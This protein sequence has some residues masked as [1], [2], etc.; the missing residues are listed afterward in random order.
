MNKKKEYNFRITVQEIGW[1]EVHAY[2]EEDAIE[3]FKLMCRDKNE[4]TEH[5]KWVEGEVT[6]IDLQKGETFLPIEI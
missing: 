3:K 4:A 6:N 5:Q 2:N 1:V